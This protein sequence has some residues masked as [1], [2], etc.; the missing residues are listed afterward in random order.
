[1]SRFQADPELIKILRDAIRHK[2]SV[3][4]EGA[5]EMVFGIKDLPEKLKSHIHY[6]AY[7]RGHS[8]GYAEVLNEYFDVLDTVDATMNAFGVKSWA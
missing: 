3:D 7:E 8:S 5:V 6:M 2:I 1:M 4:F